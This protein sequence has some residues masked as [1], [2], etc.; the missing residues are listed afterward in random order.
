M[1]IEK[2]D[3]INSLF[4]FYESLLTAKQKAYVEQYYGED[5]SL[6]EIAENFAVS[7]QAVYDNIKRTEVILEKYER[8]LQ[9]YADFLRRNQAADAVANYVAEQYPDDRQLHRLIAQLETSESD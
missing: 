1:E 2:N 8:K 6:G 3:R 7:R 4:G 9:L 5:Y